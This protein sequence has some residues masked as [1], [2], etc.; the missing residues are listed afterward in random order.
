M[1]RAC[2]V[3]AA[4]VCACAL[5]ASTARAQTALEERGRF[6]VALGPLW[7]GRA[8]F[9]RADATETASSGGRFPLFST[10]SELAAA[11]GLEARVG[12]RFARRLQVEASSSYRRPQLRATISGDVENAARIAVA[13]SIQQFTFDGALVLQLA[14]WRFG[15]GGLP[16]VSAG[17]GYLRELHEG[18]TLAAAGRTF[19]VGGGVKYLIVSRDGRWKGL[20]VR[21]DVRALVRANGAALDSRAHVSPA[22][23]ASGFVRF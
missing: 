14:R 1:I 21:G 22:L 13:E 19:H 15:R 16:F 6:E 8:A 20:G 23:A 7:V 10:S 4:C 12:I 11:P 17:A 2:Q 5:P 3:A 9:G 18:R